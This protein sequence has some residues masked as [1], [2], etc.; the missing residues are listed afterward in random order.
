MSNVKAQS[1]NQAQSSN[2]ED[3]A[4]HVGMRALTFGLGA[5]DIHLTFGF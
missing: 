3:M 2:P 4:H 5:F 1:S